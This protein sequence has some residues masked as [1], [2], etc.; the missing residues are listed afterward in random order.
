ML[1]LMCL[2]FSAGWTASRLTRH[3]LAVDVLND[4]GE[5]DVAG[6][7][8]SVAV[9]EHGTENGLLGGTLLGVE[10]DVL[11]GVGEVLT[12]PLEVT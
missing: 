4:L 5:V 2:K 11:G 6:V 10:A 8:I 12:T 9:T 7:V 1:V 3:E